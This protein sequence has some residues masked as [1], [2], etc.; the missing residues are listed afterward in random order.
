MKTKST[1]LLLIA[2]VFSTAIFSQTFYFQESVQNGT[3]WHSN[4]GEVEN[5]NPDDVNSS[6]IVIQ[7]NGAGGWEETQFFP[8][9]QY[10]IQEGDKIFVSFYNPNGAAAW[11]MRM[12][13]SITGEYTWIG[14]PAHAGAAA[15]GWSEVSLDLSSYVGEDISQINI[16]PSA[17]DAI[18]VF[19][20]NVYINTT[21]VIM[22]PP[23]AATYFFDESVQNGTIWH[24]NGAEVANPNQDNV[25]PSSIVI[26]NN[27]DGGWEETQFFPAPNYTIQS[28][29]KIFVSFYNPNEA[30]AWQMRMNLSVSGD[31]TW[32]GEPAHEPDAADGWNEVSLDITPYEGEDISQINLYPS[33]GDAISVYYDNIYIAN[34]TVLS[35][36]EMNNQSSNDIAY[37]N[38]QGLVKFYNNQINA[39][40]TVYDITGK[41]IFQEQISNSSTSKSSLNKRGI[42]IVSIKKGEDVLNLKLYNH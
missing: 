1:F 12:N 24:S 18:S 41:Q 28:G 5:P 39:I 38:S 2:I 36:N 8:S 34:A 16:Y 20:D 35:V 21:S 13:L 17:G 30:G 22:D 3:I 10:T 23:S 7:N 25:N 42:Y 15:T 9:P 31:F 11:Q 40:V 26:M 4:G 29:D 19:Y 14:E 32:I 33:A 37:I 6:A 27:G